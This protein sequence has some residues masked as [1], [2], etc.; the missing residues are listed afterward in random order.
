M[1]KKNRLFLLL[2]PCL[3]L[4]VICFHRQVI[5][6]VLKQVVSTQITYLKDTKVSY[7]HIGYNK[8]SLYL[9]EISFFHAASKEEKLHIDKLECFFSCKL[10]PFKCHTSYK[11][12][13]PSIKWIPSSKELEWKG[14][15][16]HELLS[17]H[18]IAKKVSIEQGKIECL[19]KESPTMIY[20]SFEP[21]KEGKY[22]GH[23]EVGFNKE[24]F[25]H[26][27]ISLYKSYKEV[28]MQMQFHEMPLKMIQE[29]GSSTRLQEGMKIDNGLLNGIIQL[30]V[31]SQNVVHYFKGDLE[32]K[33]I[34]LVYKDIT[35]FFKAKECKFHSYLPLDRQD[36]LDLRELSLPTLLQYLVSTV[37]LQ[38]GVFH[39]NNPHT[40]SVWQLEG[41]EG[42]TTFNLEQTPV[43]YLK[44]TLEKDSQSYPFTIQGK[45]V[46]E[47]EKNWWMD[48]DFC[49]T[50]LRDSYHTS[51]YVAL[52][53]QKEYFI[54]T[55]LER[56]GTA[57]LNMLQDLMLMWA[58]SL[59]S[60]HLIEGSLSTDITLQIQD[61]KIQSLAFEALTCSD[62]KGQLRDKELTVESS[63]IK[64]KA[65]L[66][67]PL[68]KGLKAS[69]WEV[70][71]EGLTLA[72][73]EGKILLESSGFLS[74][75]DWKMEGSWIKTKLEGIEGEFNINGLYSQLEIGGAFNFH[76]THL[77]SHFQKEVLSVTQQAHTLE[78]ID[79]SLKANYEKNAVGIL[80]TTQLNY[81]ENGIDQV[82]FGIDFSL[83]EFFKEIV[84]RRGWFESDKISENTYLWLIKYY[85]QK[86]YALG[87]M[88]ASG[89]FDD[90]SIHFILESNK[91]VY[92]SE[93]I[94]VKMGAQD[95]G[96]LE[97]PHRGDF[98]FDLKK[99]A[100]IIQLPITS[101]ECID[102][103]LHLPFKAVSTDVKIEGLQLTAENISAVCENIN[104]TGRLDLDFTDPD[105]IDL[106]LYPKTMQGEAA[107]FITFMRYLPDF[108]TFNLPI[109]GKIEGEVGNY[110]FTRYNLDT[111]E[112]K[113]KIAFKVYEA[114]CNVNPHCAIE[115]IVFNLSWDSENNYLEIK[116]FK[117][118]ISLQKEEERRYY[119][120]NA[121]NM[122]SKNISEGEWDFDIRIEAPTFDVFRMEG[123][124]KKIGE[125][126][127][128][129]LH[130]NLT[131]FFGAKLNVTDFVISS[132]F[133]IKTAH[134]KSD[135]SSRDLLNQLQW[136]YLC[137]F[138]DLKP[139]VFQE[140]KNTKTEGDLSFTLSYDKKDQGLLVE[141]ESS[142]LIFD[143][144]AISD[145]YMKAFKNR[146]SFILKELKTKD[147]SIFAT[148]Q[149]EEGYWKIPE[150]SMQWKH[151]FM[152]IEKGRYVDSALELDIDELSLKLEEIQQLF[153]FGKEFKE[154]LCG[155]L[156][157]KGNL[158][159]DFSEGF[160]K[161]KMHSE[162]T[163]S[164]ESI[165]KAQLDMVSKVPFKISYTSEEGIQLEHLNLHLKKDGLD[166]VWTRI[167]LRHLKISPYEKTSIGKGI[168]VI[169]PP[170][171]LIYLGSIHLLPHVEI[172][173]RAIS[174]FGKTFTWDNQIDTDLDFAYANQTLQIQGILKDG[175][176]WVGEKSL[177]LQKFHYFLDQDQLNL[178]FGC[179]YHDVSL[180][181]LTKIQFKEGLEAKVSVKEGHVE[182]HD[183]RES[184][185]I[186][187]RYAEE[188]GFYLQSIEGALY[189]IDF[190]FRR[191]PRTYLPYVMVLTGQMKID[192]G[193]LVKSF[194]KFFYQ[195]VKD[196]GMGSGYELSGDWVFSKKDIKSS[197]FK[198]FLKGRD[199]E[200]LGFYF[201]T[202]LSEVEINSRGIAIHDFRL[203][204]MSGVAQI[205]EAKVQKSEEDGSW[206]LEIP[207][208]M[209]QD[210]R[211]SFLRKYE[212]QE[213]RI[214]P[215][216]IKDLHFF[217]IEGTLGYKESFS[218]RGYLD[219][220]NTFKRETNLLDIPIEIMGRIGFDL[221][222]FVPVIGKLDFEM[223]EGKIFLRELKNTYS[224]GKRSRFYLPG[225]KDSYIAL[226][227]NLFIDIK[228]KQYVLLKITEP[229]TL[230][231][232]GSLLKPR[233]SLR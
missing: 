120:L 136:G 231:I 84:L 127:Q 194:P 9:D 23:F 52:L 108:S 92:E 166:E 117:G 121:Q 78:K 160:K 2:I 159:I 41:L 77:L 6:F 22:L 73:K 196:L 45:G 211:P 221:G 118:E 69:S 27:D 63:E 226:D 149:K 49:R 233:Y 4:A 182:E 82:R 187:C 103:K 189:G 185:E 99:R 153:S 46:I 147:V 56:L 100:W 130:P 1:L 95:T 202:L 98:I 17:L 90:K 31:T 155:D 67:F 60:F 129:L 213:E 220:I 172:Q 76:E 151:S 21:G 173:D 16:L 25:K 50:V 191:N 150:L 5:C 26:I 216:V 72:E 218:G 207:E 135:F 13:K 122:I 203:S 223:T 139:S 200:F 35:S 174:M 113:S 93:D 169:I 146:D 219:F 110:L 83:K 65:K 19:R 222:L 180:D 171:M 64:G 132:D 42:T 141:I 197:Y 37:E 74:S 163:A 91:A 104:F 227:G 201:K 88:K 29:F 55:H 176:Y 70:S 179:D 228:M 107:D 119:H 190:S 36:K 217:N 89:E 192:T 230:S 148:A 81:A 20:L 186:A 181:F 143:Q 167:D 156:H 71:F 30:G 111:S 229:F 116:D 115:D 210:F 11:V 3:F 140:I 144:F 195:T 138:L 38:E 68:F 40:H 15:N 105:W 51:V 188:E 33:E 145:L 18:P 158:S 161:W 208:V 199:F 101:A 102:K 8:N 10:A 198:G 94:T 184:L 183:E 112:K 79:F 205:K 61:K 212:G 32:A 57:Q 177:Y 214:K 87:D 154:V 47:S 53:D 225:H 178:V 125:D 44:G 14:I 97:T 39:F 62:L 209:V 175:Y 96:Y 109:Q 168:K 165:T 170:E 106:K 164:S 123:H 66:Y 59:D 224:E 157:A 215:F 85:K 137:G 75:K 232:R 152:T 34:S 80:G 131:H 114:T 124:T 43:I 126:F 204:D 54:K 142:A 128:I 24:D 193:G 206:R 48:L 86:W 134:I 58:P 162:M 28:L 12:I 133:Q 7:A